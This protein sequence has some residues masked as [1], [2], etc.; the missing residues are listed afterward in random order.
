[1]FNLQSE[2]CDLGAL[3]TR[4]GRRIAFIGGI[5]SGLMLSGGP[6]DVKQAVRAAIETLGREGGLI[7]APDQPLA[8]PP[9]N[10]AALA[11]AAREFG[12][13]REVA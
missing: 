8:F 12:V 13:Y 1:V 2:A 6:E 4:Y 3:H 9:E 7:L 10:E 5:P 11:E